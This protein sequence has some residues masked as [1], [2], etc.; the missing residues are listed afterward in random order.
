MPHSAKASV[1][2]FPAI[3]RNLGA[4]LGQEDAA[5]MLKG[6]YRK[7]WLEN[8][9][10]FGAAGEVL[11][12]LAE[13]GTPTVLLKGAALAAGVYKDLGARPMT[14]V[15]ILIPIEKAEASYEMLMA[16]GWRPLIEPGGDM[17]HVVQ[18]IRSVD[19]RKE[20]GS[21]DLHWHVMSDSCDPDD[22]D[23]FWAESREL[24]LNGTP[25]RMLAPVDQLLHLIVH[26]SKWSEWRAVHWALDAYKVIEV[27]AAEI[28]WQRL[29]DQTQKR[30]VVLPVL[31]GLELLRRDL[32]VA[33]PEYVFAALRRMHVGVV[34]R[35]EYRSQGAGDTLTGVATRELS[36]YLKRT[37]RRSLAHR[38]RGWGWYLQAAWS[39]PHP[40][41]LPLRVAQRL[42]NRLLQTGRR[43]TRS[44]TPRS[45]PAQDDPATV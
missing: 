15:D 9:M 39:V 6:T 17:A 36:G 12:A 8:Q 3:Y 11:K 21:I 30:S 42:S 13:A 28:D 14:D 35:I 20:R 25:T 5:A 43:L 37:R 33:V 40:S 27:F 4:E 16:R 18:V 32:E 26:G 38:L 10:L 19:L 44:A 2:L 22:D 41:Q 31:V 45:H 23:D 34:E 1:D 7:T 24:D 29:L